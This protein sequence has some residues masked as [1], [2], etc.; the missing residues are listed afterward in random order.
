MKLKHNSLHRLIMNYS[1]IN[2]GLFH[3]TSSPNSLHR[4]PDAFK[5]IPINSTLNKDFKILCKKYE[6]FNWM[7]SGSYFPDINKTQLEHFIFYLNQL[8]KKGSV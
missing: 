1:L 4:L 5:V 6:L 2:Q 3:E 8:Y 7:M